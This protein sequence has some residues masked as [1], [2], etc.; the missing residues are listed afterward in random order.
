MRRHGVPLT[1]ILRCFKV[2]CLLGILCTTIHHVIAAN[3]PSALASVGD[4]VVFSLSVFVDTLIMWDFAF[5]PGFVTYSKTC[6]KRPLSKRPK[7]GFQDQV[8]FNAG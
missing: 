2:A 7:I 8:L 4:S 3:K 1:L 6:V 5:S